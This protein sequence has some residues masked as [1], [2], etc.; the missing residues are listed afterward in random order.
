MAWRIEKG[1]K[2]KEVKGDAARERLRA[3]IEDGRAF[4]ILAFD[5]DVPVGWCS[6]GP[7]RDY[8][9]ID[10]APSLACDDADRVWSIPCFFVRK[11][12]RGQG[13]STAML[14]AATAAIRSRGGTVAEAYP[15][16]PPQDGKPIPSAFAWSGPRAMFDADGFAVVG[17][18]DGGRQRVRKVL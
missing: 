18:P 8:P 7:R 5:G 10:R 3:M 6:F 2:W 13:V 16:K 9:R 1:E 15:A 17:N 12:F 11:G 14:D 4:A